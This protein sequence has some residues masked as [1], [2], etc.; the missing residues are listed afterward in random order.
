[1]GFNT[2]SVLQMNVPHCKFIR[3]LPVF[4]TIQKEQASKEDGAVPEEQASMQ[5]LV[6]FQEHNN[7]GICMM[8]FITCYNSVIAK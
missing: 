3:F 5:I 8:T 4:K 6:S 2:V 1:M 7:F